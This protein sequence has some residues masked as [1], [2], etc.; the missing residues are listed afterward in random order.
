MM[1]T[2]QLAY[3]IAI[4]IL[5]LCY[6]GLVVWVIS[7]VKILIGFVHI[8]NFCDTHQLMSKCKLYLSFRLVALR[9]IYGVKLFI[10][11]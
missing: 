8:S 2:I 1:Q 11:D 9:I 10:A 4:V 6:L 3:C 7:R 5:C